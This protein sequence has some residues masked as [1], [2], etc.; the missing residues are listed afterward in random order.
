MWG[1]ERMTENQ[2]NANLKE[3]QKESE[4]PLR[5]FLLHSNFQPEIFENFLVSLSVTSR[6][7]SVPTN[8]KAIN[9]YLQGKVNE[10]IVFE[11]TN[12][13]IANL[14]IEIMIPSG[15]NIDEILP[16]SDNVF[17]P[18]IFHN[19]KLKEA[20]FLPNENIVHFVKTL[21]WDMDKS[22][23]IMFKILSKTP[24]YK[25]MSDGFSYQST[26]E[27]MAKRLEIEHCQNISDN[28]IRPTI[29]LFSYY[30]LLTVESVEI[31]IPDEYQNTGY[32]NFNNEPQ[33]EAIFS[34]VD[35]ADED[36][37]EPKKTNKMVMGEFFENLFEDSFIEKDHPPIIK[38]GRAKEVTERIPISLSINISHPYI[39]TPDDIENIK[40]TIKL[41]KT[42]IQGER[43]M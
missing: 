19:E 31:P 38:I 28:D 13:W 36:K 23:I 11:L 42:E 10:E 2:K 3:M 22:R 16:T 30:G 8:I 4:F 26:Y 39:L 6:H 17:S 32:N 33:Y 24:A 27:Q 7:G 20:Q 18:Y 1:E 35:K 5:F 12:F 40:K 15:E 25:K 29:D 9:G 37:K 43:K 34:P 41:I 14:E 21:P